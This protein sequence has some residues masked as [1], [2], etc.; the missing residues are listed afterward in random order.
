MNFSKGRKVKD[1]SV[2]TIFDRKI[3]KSSSNGPNL[4]CSEGGV[5]R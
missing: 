2:F 4:F 3:H 5:K 1:L